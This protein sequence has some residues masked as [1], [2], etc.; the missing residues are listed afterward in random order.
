MVRIG[1][2][3]F[4]VRLESATSRH[5]SLGVFAVA[6][7]IAERMTAA[8]EGEVIGD[9][10]CVY[11]NMPRFGLAGATRFVPA[12]EPSRVRQRAHVAASIITRR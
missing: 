1:A 6:K 8:T 12:V 9:F 4:A 7:I 10:E 5:A 2:K 3:A 11:D